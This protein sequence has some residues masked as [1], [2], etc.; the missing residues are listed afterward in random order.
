M[1]VI[2]ICYGHKDEWESKDE[3]IKYY[4]ECA[5]ASEGSERERYMTIIL[6]LLDGQKV[7]TDGSEK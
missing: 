6:Q 7:A 3:A 5:N 1:K 2:T 4:M